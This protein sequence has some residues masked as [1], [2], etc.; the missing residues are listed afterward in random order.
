MEYYGFTNE[1]YSKV[2]SLLNTIS[3]TGIN[4]ID[5]FSEATKILRAPMLINAKEGDKQ[6]GEE[7]H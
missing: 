1:Q 4:Q 7:I 3:V 5:A 2:I 6:D